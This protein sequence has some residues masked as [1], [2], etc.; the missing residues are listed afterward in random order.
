MILDLIVP[1]YHMNSHYMHGNIEPLGYDICVDST[2]GVLTVNTVIKS[3]PIAIVI[4]SCPIAI[5]YVIILADLI[6]ISLQEFDVILK[7]DW[8]SKNHVIID[9]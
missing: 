8:L 3:C 2:G 1:S 4:K 5:D 7:M 6:V 9:C